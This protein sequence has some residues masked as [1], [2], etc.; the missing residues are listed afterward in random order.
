MLFLFKYLVGSKRIEVL[1][2][3][4]YYLVLV[5]GMEKKYVMVSI[6]DEKSKDMAKV[7]SNATAR[8]VLDLLS[9]KDKLSAKQIAKN[10]GLRLNTVMYNLKALKKQ[11]LIK[12]S[13]FG[14]SEKGKKVDMY[15]LAQKI[16]VIAPKGFD[17]QEVLK[18]IIPVALVGFGLALLTKLYSAWDFASRAAYDTMSLESVEETV[19]VAQDT[20]VVNSGI[21]VQPW[22]IIVGITLLVIIGILVWSYWK[23]KKV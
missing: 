8:K 6:D 16:V 14:W 19:I 2:E 13:D 12:V 9:S 11:G 15:S 17:Y 18:K 1:K 22:M 23:H 4:I 5:S 20:F 21:S 10:L 3:F 7:I